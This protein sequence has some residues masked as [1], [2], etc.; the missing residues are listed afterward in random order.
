MSLL[1]PDVWPYGARKPDSLVKTFSR[2]TLSFRFAC[3]AAAAAAD[4]GEGG[5]NIMSRQSIGSSSAYSPAGIFRE[6]FSAEDRI[7][8]IFS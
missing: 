6:H 3:F 7:Q 5:E 1:W 2:K 4:S 8:K